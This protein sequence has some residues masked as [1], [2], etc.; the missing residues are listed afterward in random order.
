MNN[1]EKVELF[2]EHL[3]E[4]KVFKALQQEINK[5]R[6]LDVRCFMMLNNVTDYLNDED[7]T[8]AASL[9]NQRID[10]S[11]KIMKILIGDEKTLK[12]L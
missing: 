2:G 10:V 1:N 7:F 6:E 11:D 3:K 5:R 8:S 12:E 4:T 9:C